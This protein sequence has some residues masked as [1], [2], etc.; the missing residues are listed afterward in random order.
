MWIEYANPGKA[1]TLAVSLSNTNSQVFFLQNHGIIV[2]AESAEEAENVHAEINDKIKDYFGIDDS[3]Y[4]VKEIAM[5][6]TVSH[7]L[8][9]DQIVFKGL[10]NTHAGLETL[11][12]YDFILG[13]M[14]ECNLTPNFLSTENVDYIQ[15][16][17]SEKY[18]KILV[19]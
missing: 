13:K 3:S 14:T 18:R 16:M 5:D 8:F 11:Y 6:A 19:K 10:T 4:Q 1:I 17:S 2:C 15:N 7:A 12:A 9:P